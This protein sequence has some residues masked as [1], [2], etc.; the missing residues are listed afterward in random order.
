MSKLQLLNEKIISTKAEM[1]G[2][3]K[4]SRKETELTKLEAKIE[5]NKEQ[6]KKN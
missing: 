3:E 5:Q 6:H 4:H 2:G 1:W